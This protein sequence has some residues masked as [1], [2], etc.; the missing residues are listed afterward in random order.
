MCLCLRTFLQLL[1]LAVLMATLCCM[2]LYIG[3]SARCVF[4]DNEAEED[5]ANDDHLT[6][7]MTLAIRNA[8]RVKA[9]QAQAVP[10]KPRIACHINTHNTTTKNNN[11]L[12]NQ[13]IQKTKNK[14]E[15]KERNTKREHRT[16]QPN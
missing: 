2:I 14:N 16:E 6:A 10:G 15:T 3:K 8:L 9:N 4:V 5:S 1:Q 12:I 13:G 7:A 11:I